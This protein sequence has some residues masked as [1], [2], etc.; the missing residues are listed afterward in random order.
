MPATRGVIGG[1]SSDCKGADKGGREIAIGEGERM[2]EME[3]EGGE[4][5]REIKKIQNEF[6]DFET[7]IYS[8]SKFF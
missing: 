5:M 8:V 7:Q 6:L 3:R 4:K 1:Q 2:I